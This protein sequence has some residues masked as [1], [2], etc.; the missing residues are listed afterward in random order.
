M[1]LKNI[2]RRRKSNFY[3]G[4]FRQNRENKFWGKRNKSGYISSPVLQNHLKMSHG[5][6]AF[7]KLTAF[8][9]SQKGTDKTHRENCRLTPENALMLAVPRMITR[10]MSCRTLTLSHLLRTSADHRRAVWVVTSLNSKLRAISQSGVQFLRSILIMCCLRNY[11][12]WEWLGVRRAWAPS[13]LWIRAAAKLKLVGVGQAWGL[14]RLL[15]NTFMLE[16]HFP[17]C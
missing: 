14:R 15:P 9:S 1:F 5:N 13:R 3:W 6:S 7:H 2:W 10:K 17:E 8:I 12:P 11:K 4:K 16:A